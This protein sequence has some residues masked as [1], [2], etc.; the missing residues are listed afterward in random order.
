MMS[1]RP[2]RRGGDR[3]ATLVEYALGVALIAVVSLGA[4][5]RI[6][7]RGAAR[8]EGSDDRISAP[9]DNQYYP[10]LAT[11][12]TVGGTTTT[13]TAGSSPVHVRSNPVVVVENQTQSEWRVTVTFTVVDSSDQGVI[14]ATI[15]G[16]WSDGGNGS[17]PGGTCTTSTGAGSCTVQYLA[18]KD[19]VPSVTFT[20]SSI[21][22]GS[23][24][25]QPQAA[26]E[27]T[28]AIACQPPLNNSC[29]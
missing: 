10:G 1:Q 4:I 9:V 28:V 8:L 11:T 22:G 26:G 14:G 21:S 6:E 13:T 3:G 18:I 27:G 29:D 16:T 19:N 12:T 17:Q 2:L 5:Q 15:T 23:F 25:W 7:D 24:S 20:M